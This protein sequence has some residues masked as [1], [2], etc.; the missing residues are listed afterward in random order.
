MPNADSSATIR[1]SRKGWKKG[2]FWQF[3]VPHLAWV[4]NDVLALSDQRRI[5]KNCFGVLRRMNGFD[6][7]R[8]VSLSQVSTWWCYLQAL[9]MNLSMEASIK[10]IWH[11]TGLGCSEMVWIDMYKQLSAKWSDSENR[12]YSLCRENFPGIDLPDYALLASL[13]QVVWCAI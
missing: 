13:K 1:A 9:T 3:C 4:H 5:S 8:W 11:M 7:T 6:T 10:H 2:T 12:A